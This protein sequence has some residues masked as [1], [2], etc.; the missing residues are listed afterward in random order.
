MPDEAP[1]I[2]A[3]RDLRSSAELLDVAPAAQVLECRGDIIDT[4][5]ILLRLLRRAAL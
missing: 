5:H 2:I 3:V 4:M 1:V